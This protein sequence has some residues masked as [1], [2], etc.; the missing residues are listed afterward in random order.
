PDLPPDEEQDEVELV[1]LPEPSCAGEGFAPTVQSARMVMGGTMTLLEAKTGLEPPLSELELELWGEPAGIELATPDTPYS[2]CKRCVVLYANCDE[3]GCA[4]VYL[5]ESGSIRI[6]QWDDARIKENARLRGSFIGLT[7]R[8][9]SIE[10]G[11]STPLPSAQG[12]C[13]SELAF[14]AAIAPPPTP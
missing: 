14:D 13:L 7:L 9:V 8:P 11:E 12:W 1:E 4:Q 5:A 3:E 2:S 10:D 6:D